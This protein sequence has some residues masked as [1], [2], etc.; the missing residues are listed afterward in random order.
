MPRDPSAKID[1]LKPIAQPVIKDLYDISD[2]ALGQLK[3]Y[4]EQS[5][6]K[7]PISQLEG[8]AQIGAEDL[9]GV[10]VVA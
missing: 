9:V 7:L 4:I 3:T 5:G 2:E 6:L 10:E 1:P 8:S